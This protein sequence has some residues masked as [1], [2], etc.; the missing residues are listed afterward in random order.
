MAQTNRSTFRKLVR[1]RDAV[2]DSLT[3]NHEYANVA[4]VVA[5]AKIEKKLGRLE[6]AQKKKLL[7]LEIAALPEGER[8]QARFERELAPYDEKDKLDRRAAKQ[9][10]KRR[11]E[12]EGQEAA[13]K[14]LEGELSKLDARREAFVA[15]LKTKYPE[16]A[17]T[18]VDAAALAAYE[19]AQ[20][21][22]DAAYKALSEK[23]QAEKEKKLT[24]TRAR[25]SSENAKLQAKFDSIDAQLRDSNAVD[26][27]EFGEGNIVQVKNL[28]MYFS[29]IKA[30]D[31]LSFNIKEGEIFGLIG[32]NGAGKTTVFNCLTQF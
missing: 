22:A 15:S 11:A 6:L 27:K 23:L 18:A 24:A 14:Y 4:E 25:L 2:F 30:V 16:T 1:T 20:S 19:K 10:A 29:G 31:D 8:N 3:F 17:S 26:E 32:P 21:E 7:P 12:K 13:D 5:D 9:E 28:K